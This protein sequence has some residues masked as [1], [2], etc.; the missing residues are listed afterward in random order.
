MRLVLLA[1]SIA[2]LIGLA[3]GGRPGRLAE[4][5]LRWPV[6]GLIGIGLQLIP[7]T[8]AVGMALL[9][10]SFAFL[11]AVTT[12][13]LRL[14]GFPLIMVGLALNLLVISV[15]G[16]M[17][18]TADALIR[19]GQRATM[20]DLMHHGGSKHHL[21]TDSDRLVELADAIPIGPPIRQA[22][23]VGDILAY[24]GVAWFV[25]RGMHRRRAV[26][27]PGGTADADVAEAS[28]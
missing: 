8:G 21:A 11:G 28:P 20:T 12:A 24:A 17:P 23:S 25:I 14:P 5:R 26:R 1:L 4:I 3:T 10:S 2:L 7:A 16:G 9:L 13:N 19:S 22:V 18:V 27:S 15:N 6:L